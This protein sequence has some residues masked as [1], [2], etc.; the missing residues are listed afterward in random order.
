MNALIEECI[1]N[2]SQMLGEGRGFPSL[3][4]D[5]ADPSNS[6][7]LREKSFH[8]RALGCVTQ[9]PM[10]LSPPGSL[11]P[12]SLLFLFLPRVLTCPLPSSSLLRKH[13][14]HPALSPRNAPG[15]A[16]IPIWFS[17]FPAP[18]QQVGSILPSRQEARC[19]SF[20]FPSQLLSFP[21]PFADLGP[22]QPRR[23]ASVSSIVQVAPWHLLLPSLSPP[24]PKV[25]IYHS[26]PDIGLHWFFQIFFFFSLLPGA[27]GLPGVC[28]SICRAHTFS[29]TCVHAHTHACTHV[30]IH[31][32]ADLHVQPFHL[33]IGVS[34]SVSMVPASCWQYSQPLP[35]FPWLA[36]GPGHVFSASWEN[37]GILRQEKWSVFAEATAFIRQPRPPT[38]PRETT[39]FTEHLYLFTFPQ[40][41]HRARGQYTLQSCLLPSGE[42]LGYYK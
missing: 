39:G 27:L 32:C 10:E 30:C 19:L 2:P 3:P 18:Y 26:F 33:W 15:P 31:T 34:L 28:L 36:G 12:L 11:P 21:G 40:F 22:E 5:A 13:L 8:L 6:T 37:R 38:C 25:N 7:D 41:I 4:A 14:P 1:P 20:S 42:E 17:C 29:L 24:I 16:Q 35:L 23:A 9:V